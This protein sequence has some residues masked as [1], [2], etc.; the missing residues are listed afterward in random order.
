MKKQKWQFWV[1]GCCTYLLSSCLG[2]ND[3][4]D[5]WYDSNCLISSFQ[6]L[7]DSVPGLENVKFTIDQVNGLIYNA[8]SMPYGTEIRWKVVCQVNFEA[9]PSSVEV[10]QSA[11]GD[12]ASWNQKDSLDFSSYVR[13]DV[14]SQDQKNFK[15]YFA[16]INIHQQVPDS[17]KWQWFSNRLLGK[18]V[19]EQKVI[20]YDRY[21]LMYA[22]T[23]NGYELYRTPQNDKRT[24]IP[25]PLSGFGSKTFNLNQLTEFKGAYYV[26][27]TDGSLYSSANGQNWTQLA[28]TPVVKTLLGVIDSSSVVNTQPLLAAVIQEDNA[29]YF[30]T[31]G[32]DYQWKKGVAVPAGFPVTGF[33]N[34][35]YKTAFYWHLLIAT[36]KDRYGNLR[37]TVWETMDGL[38]WVQSTD[39]RFTIIEK[40]EGVM[41]TSYDNKL[42]LIGGINASNTAAKDIYYSNDR[43]ITW[44]LADSMLYLPGTYRP[45]G[46]ASVIVDQDNFLH[47]FG[48]KENNS[49]NHLDE[50]WSGRIN[51]LGFKP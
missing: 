44:A 51:R 45:R 34:A 43:G 7:S 19:Q 9:F 22:K 33:G 10:F 31:M 1:L 14:F 26:P 15:R 23:A 42:F 38:K 41:L 50:L 49:A 27:A 47:L 37:N 6:L 25:V 18:T 8:D 24:W 32:I 4:Y 46:Y 21:Y 28:Q 36:G 16:Q 48:G 11:T 13:F 40:R 20:A 3:K 12:S 5:P 35:T 17:M 2:T 29:Y 39:E 30:A